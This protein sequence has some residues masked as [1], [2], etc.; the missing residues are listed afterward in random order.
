MKYAVYE[1][2]ITRKFAL[3]PLPARF[4]EGD[5]VPLRN[6]EQ[7]FDTRDA[8]VATVRDLLSRSE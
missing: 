8:A 4:V 3:V 6:N 2:P 1:H 5:A 7:W